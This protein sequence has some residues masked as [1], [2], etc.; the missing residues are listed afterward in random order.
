MTK[1]GACGLLSSPAMVKRVDGPRRS[2]G[3]ERER[4]PG[5]WLLLFAVAFALRALYAWLAAGPGALPSSDAAEYDTVAWNLARGLGFS[6]DVHG[7]PTAFVP[8]VVPWI[9]SL[10]YRAA[11]HHYFEALL[12]QCAIGALVPLLVASLGGALFGGPAGRLAG[13]LTAFHPLLVFFSGYLL[14]ETTF[15]ATLLLALLLTAEWVK[16]PRPG[17]ALGAG[18]AWGVAALTRPT[19]LMLPQLLALWAWVPLGLTVMPRERVRQ[20]LLLLLGVALV[21]GP[22]TLRNAS[23][24]HAFVPITT[25]SGRALLDSNNPEVW[26]DPV[27]RGG[28]GRIDYFSPTSEFHGLSETALDARARARAVEFLRGHA[29]EWPAMALAKLA[30]FWRLTAE[31]GG[32]GA[33]Q[34]AGSPLTAVLR[35]LDPL[36][37]WSIF[38]LP[39]ALWGLVRVVRGPRRWFQLLPAVVIVYLSALAVVFWG[40]LRMRLPAEPLLML[41]TAV[42]IEDVRRRLRGRVAGL[43]VV[44]GHR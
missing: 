36:A 5:P 24:L 27:Q 2:R 4:H 42:G 14:T 28:A 11:G 19:A 40:A 39:F 25:G 9:T 15:C 16:T 7:T 31:G 18:L 32:T 34:R 8:P 22:W 41:F 23:V 33:W 10:L 20:T 6:L 3:A 13:W 38:A 26:S 21:V 29:R 30:R 12:V 35:V 17:R 37:V 44:E 1:R 43:R